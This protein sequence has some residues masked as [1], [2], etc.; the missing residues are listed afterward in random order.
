MHGSNWLPTT[1]SAEP[2]SVFKELA[3]SLWQIQLEIG[4]EDRVVQ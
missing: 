4:S 3:L 2:D 1:Q